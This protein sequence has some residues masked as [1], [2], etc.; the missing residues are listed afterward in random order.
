MGALTIFRKGLLGRL[1]NC[2]HRVPSV[3]KPLSDRLSLDA[4]YIRPFGKGL[5]LVADA[6]LEIIGPVVLLLFHR[7]PTAIGWLVIPIWVNAIDR[8]FRGWRWSHIGQEGCVIF[9][10]SVANFDASTSVNLI[11]GIG[12]QVTPLPHRFPDMVELCAGL[13]VRA[14]QIF[15]ALGAYF[16]AL[17]SAGS[18]TAL[19]KPLTS[20]KR[21]VSAITATIPAHNRFM[22][23][24]WAASDDCELAYFPAGKINKLGHVCLGVA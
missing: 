21:L 16:V 6:N 14:V 8:M 2:C 24:V 12:S 3:F 23:A 9:V 5:R 4:G 18:D 1:K 13:S 15:D 22:R 11:I 20:G 17:A 7:G 10:P 19:A